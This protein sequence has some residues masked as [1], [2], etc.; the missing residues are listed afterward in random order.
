MNNISEKR[1]K[2][3]VAFAKFVL[4]HLENEEEWNADTT[5]DIA[6]MAYHMELAE[7]GEHGMFQ[8]TK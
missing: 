6:K 1:I 5:D 7:T 4:T 2:K 8:V 3:L